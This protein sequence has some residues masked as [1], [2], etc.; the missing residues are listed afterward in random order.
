MNKRFTSAFTLFLVA[1]NGFA[2]VKNGGG[3]GKD[4]GKEHWSGVDL[5]SILIGIAIGLIIGY[6]LGKRSSKS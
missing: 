6:F 1:A 5:Y 3:V 4:T 2:Q